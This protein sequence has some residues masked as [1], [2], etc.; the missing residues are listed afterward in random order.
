MPKQVFDDT[1]SSAWVGVSGA[2]ALVPLVV[3]GLWGGSIADALDRRT[4]LLVTNAGIALTSLGLWLQAAAD[5][6]SVWGVLVLLALQQACFGLNAP[7]RGAAVPRL[8]PGDLLT[9]AAALSTSVSSLGLVLGP[10][11]A[12]V[13]IPV[14]GL[15]TLYLVDTVGLLVAVLLTVGLPR[16]PP[17]ARAGGEVR[18]PGLRSV[19]EGGRY[20]LVQRILLVSFLA[21]V[22]AMVFGMP[23]A[24]FPEPGRAIVRRPTRR[25]PGA[26]RALRGDPARCRCGRA[27]LGHL[28]AGAAAGPRGRAGRGRVGAGRRRVRAGRAAVAGRG[29]PR[30]RRG[31]RPG[32]LLVPRRDPAAGHHRRD[33]RPHAG[34]LH[35]GGRRR[36][37]AGRPAARHA[38]RPARATGRGHRRR[39]AGG[40]RHRAR[41]QPVPRLLALPGAGARRRRPVGGGRRRAARGRRP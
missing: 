26:R 32:R 39:S 19:L 20:L 38:G 18:S 34:L 24:L 21:D 14:V 25:W 27:A 17:L 2:V 5:S 8:V 11:L 7:A 30:P 15:P 1:G 12:G 23:R 3:F 40:R 37:P 9:A 13:L 16:L 22:V 28:H 41:R 29:V 4:L 31:R 6:H 33:A 35:R 10:L 36:S